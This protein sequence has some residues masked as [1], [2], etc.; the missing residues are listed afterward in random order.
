M[1]KK[2][3]SFI[4][5]IL[6]GTMLF[7]CASVAAEKPVDIMARTTGTV[8]T[9]AEKAVSRSIS[10]EFINAYYDFSLSMVK[11]TAQ[12]NKNTLVSPLSIMLALGMAVNGADKDT[13]TE[14]ES[15]LG[16]I[17]TDYL[18]SYLYTYMQSLESG[19]SSGSPKF[20]AANS[21]WI[22]D[23]STLKI[24]SSFLEKCAGYYKAQAYKVDFSKKSTI[25][26]IDDWVKT[27]TDGMIDKISDKFDS[28]IAVLLI[29]ALAFEGEW[30]TK[31]EENKISDGY[32]TNADN[33]TSNVKFMA[34]NEYKYISG[35]NAVGFIKPYT[36]KYAFA[37]I[38]PDEDVEKYLETLTSEELYKMISGASNEKVETVLPKFKY[39][40]EVSLVSALQT[41]GMKKAFNGTLAD[42]S[43]MGTVEGENLYIGDVVHKTYIEVAEK[44]TKAGA[45]TAVILYG[46]GA[47]IEDEVKKVVLDRPFIYAI[48]DTE[49]NL[50]IFI[51]T[52]QNLV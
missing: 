28:E 41:M 46:T 45:V 5:V 7:G 17:K 4:S 25:D 36:E 32:F 33:S 6:A 50:P 31:Y 14:M 15:A 52:I 47:V 48:I 38:L 11:N 10:Q 21:I 16:G 35:K 23:D 44:G 40:F 43:K 12:K 19:K 22:K 39:D 30:Q 24:H 9:K 20:H 34:S 18:N 27:N 8:N 3:A 29:N 26:A 13:R 49:T 1:K 42:F 2:I 37:A 51:G